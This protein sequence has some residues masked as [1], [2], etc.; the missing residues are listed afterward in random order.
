MVDN[1]FIEVHKRIIES[2][3]IKPSMMFVFGIAFLIDDLVLVEA[4]VFGRKG[5]IY[6]EKQTREND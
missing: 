6:K 2:V 1:R 3:Y 5:F 4:H